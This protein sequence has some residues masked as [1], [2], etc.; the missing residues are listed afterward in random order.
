M[1]IKWV[2]VPKGYSD[3]VWTEVC[4]LILE[5]PRSIFKGHFGSKDT[6]FQGFFLKYRPFFCNFRAL[7]WSTPENFWN[8][9]KMKQ[10]LFPQYNWPHQHWCGQVPGA[11]CLEHPILCQTCRGSLHIEEKNPSKISTSTCTIWKNCL[12]LLIDNFF[13]NNFWSVLIGN[14]IQILPVPEKICH[15]TSPCYDF[16]KPANI[17]EGLDI[18]W[19]LNDR[20]RENC[21]FCDTCSVIKC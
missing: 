4:C 19:S 12:L 5:T 18:E 13:H 14:T 2:G 8:F 16:I 21:R 1:V 7:A 20:C 17:L 3:L 9:G 6:H 10:C 11:R 15:S